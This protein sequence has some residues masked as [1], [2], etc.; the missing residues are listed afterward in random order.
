MQEENED[1]R[2]IVYEGLCPWV[3]LQLG[4]AA[5]LTATGSHSVPRRRFATPQAPF[6]KGA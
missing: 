4:H 1:G 2:K 6:E 3:S 5:A